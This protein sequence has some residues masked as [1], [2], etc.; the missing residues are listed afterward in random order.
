[1]PPSTR[2]DTACTPHR[3]T[4]TCRGAYTVLRLHLLV[5]MLLPQ[6]DAFHALRHR[7]HAAPHHPYLLRCVHCTETESAGGDAAAAE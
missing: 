4:P 6:S 3:T 5:V 2:C 1:M 7:L